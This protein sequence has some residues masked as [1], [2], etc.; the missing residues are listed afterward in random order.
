MVT[1]RTFLAGLGAVVVTVSLVW[2]GALD[3]AELGTFDRLFELRGPR[4]PSAPIVVITIDEDSFDELDVS[5]PFPRALHGKLVDVLSAAQP[6]VIG[7]D[8]VFPEP[9][10]RGPGDDEALGRAIARAGNV[11]LAAAITTVREQ[12]TGDITLNVDK[13][14]LNVPIPV[15]RRGAAAVAPVNELLDPDGHLRRA[16]VRHRLGDEILDGWDLQLYR[17]ARAKG[18]PVAPPPVG[19]E[20]LINF[21][22]GPRTFLWVPYHRVV[23]GE[24]PAETFR[25]AIV[26]IGATTPVLQD[27]FSTPFARARSMPGVE[28][29]AHVLDT[30]LR[31]DRVR[32]VPPWAS[33]GV[34]A[35]AGFA[36]A[37]LAARLRALRA[38]VAVALLWVALAL[39]TFVAFAGWDLWLRGIRVTLALVLGYGATVIDNY[40]RE[41]REKRRLSQFF[42]PDVL[43]EII[44]GQGELVLGS[45]RRRITVLFSDIRGFTSMSEKVEPEQV[46]E[47]LREYLTEMTE[48]VFRHGGT[49]DKYIG[50]CIMAL[51]NAPFDDPDHAANAIRTG[52][53]L[54][55]RTL[56]V[57]A[58]WEQRLGGQIRNGVGINTGEAVVGALGSRQRLEYTAIGDTVNL[59]SRLESL[60]KEYGTGI[61]VSESTHEIVKGQFLTKELGEVAVKG[62]AQPV[63]IYGVLPGSI[64]KYPRAAL[65]AA[66]TVVAAVGGRTWVVRT[67]D[68]SEGG[69]SVA[70]LPP[71]LELE[72][73]STVQIRCEGGVLP[74]PIAGEGKIVWRRGDQAGIAFTAGA[75]ALV[76]YVSTHKDA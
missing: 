29:H 50:D 30:L 4:P 73:G 16:A 41:Q 43:R 57:S 27:I 70:G 19:S 23:H 12:L 45:S 38:F 72:P 64:R 53:E 62:K 52:L 26:L 66:A 10:S 74:K 14:D 17:M 24:V 8:V 13:V 61:I 11:V 48:V 58:R 67:R 21:R 46:A 33:L 68:V 59:A 42:S 36:G 20:I 9:S 15:I 7:F 3:T 22:G 25:G 65:D 1:L 31:G 56:A 37:W 76:E 55:E 5:W 40:V 34:V 39:T 2:L 32:T 75:P 51:Y 35:A 71:E 63:K 28:I 49:V 6:L 18:L 44:R 60:T 54:Q 69:L 47:M